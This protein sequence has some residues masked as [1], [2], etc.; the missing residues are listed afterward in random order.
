MSLPRIDTHPGPGPDRQD[1]G[2][3]LA[4]A[5]LEEARLRCARLAADSAQPRWIALRELHRQIGMAGWYASM[6]V[7]RGR[8][9]ALL[10]T[11]HQRSDRAIGDLQDTDALAEVMIYSEDAI[12]GQLTR[13][14]HSDHMHLAHLHLLH[15]MQLISDHLS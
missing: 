2:D 1:S 6:Q 3:G 4:Y 8:R 15:A 10:A 12:A 5:L 13:D 9:L 14:A 11:A 7:D